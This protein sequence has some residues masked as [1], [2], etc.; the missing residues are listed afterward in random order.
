M[1]YHQDL[2]QAEIK[3]AQ[4]LIGGVI[5]AIL[6]TKGGTGIVGELPG[7]GL[8]VRVGATTYNVWVD[9]DPEGNGPGHLEIEKSKSK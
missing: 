4:P 9:C 1:S 8:Q 6:Q 2:V 5:T 3:N 7:F